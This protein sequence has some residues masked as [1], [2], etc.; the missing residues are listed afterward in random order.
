[1]MAN[2][3]PDA[4]LWCFADSRVSLESYS[5]KSRRLV[6]RV[7]KEIGPEVGLITFQDISFINTAASF[8]GD[9]IIAVP[10]SEL[11]RE[12]YARHP[13]CRDYVEPDDIA[14]QFCDQ[15]GAMHTV[16]AKTIQYKK[17]A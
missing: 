6:F 12:F 17:L 7:E 14:F 16:V 2:E 8:S 15:E 5:R 10:F 3:L 11:T 13:A 9:G 4:L 1:M